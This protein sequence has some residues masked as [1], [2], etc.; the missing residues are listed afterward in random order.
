MT[1]QV[2]VESLSGLSREDAESV[3][4]VVTAVLADALRSVALGVLTMDAA[5]LQVTQ[6]I[7]LV[8]SPP[9]ERSTPAEPAGQLGARSS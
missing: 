4:T 8:F 9:P 2:F 5:R 1:R 6:G 3:V 7:D